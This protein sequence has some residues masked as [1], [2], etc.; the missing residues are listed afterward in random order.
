MKFPNHVIQR[1]HH[2]CRTFVDGS[3]ASTAIKFVRDRGLDHAVER[4]KNLHPLLNVKNL[5]KS[6]PSKSLP[7]SII[8]QHK[9]LLK[10]PYRPIEFIRKYPSVFHEFL[11]GGIATHP[12]IKL[13]QEVLDVD[14]D[15]HLVYESVSY[16]QLV[17]DRLLKL[18]MISRMNKIPISILNKLKWDLGLPQNYLKT[19]VPEFPDYFRV[20]G[21]DESGQLELVCWSKELAVSVLEKKA[22]EGGYGYSMGMPLAFPVKFSPG[23]EMDKKVKKWWDD[24]QK[25][26]YVSPYENALLLSPKTD[27]SDKWS[28]AVLHEI[29]NLF[30]SKKA[31]RDDVLCLGEYLGIRSRFKRVLLQHPFIFYLS[32]KIGTYT[33][34]LKEAYK[35]GLLIESNPLM[36][37]R[38]RYLHLMRT[39]KDHD[40]DLSVSSGSSREKKASSNAPRKEAAAD[41]SEEEKNGISN[42][43][44]G[45]ET[46]PGDNNDEEDRFEGGRQASREAVA[47][48][49]GR[50][51]RSKRRN[52]DL[53]AHLRDGVGEKKMKKKHGRTNP[54]VPLEANASGNVHRRTQQRSS[55]SHQ[56]Q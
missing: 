29:M 25:L 35:R 38:N 12:H 44:S 15:E 33:V 34:V 1:S 20:V 30:V 36:N 17:A 8:S 7:I 43:F 16:R 42:A 2:G 39:V 41:D 27:E 46:E 26:P 52:V 53:K 49:N 54:K 14:V 31:E 40:K 9:D 51:T 18:L 5:I 56:K 4:E 21:A 28:A 32:S 48:S 55:N 23:F 10:I 13:T 37:I 22:M 45:S 6:E 24:W 47:V 3:A 11:P 19:L 50:T